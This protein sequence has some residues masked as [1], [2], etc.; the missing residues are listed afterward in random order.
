MEHIP[1][2]AEVTLTPEDVR[3]RVGGQFPDLG[4][5]TAEFLNE[6]FDSFAFL[7]D[8]RWV[9]LFPKRREREPL[10]LVSMRLLDEL[11][12][13]LP[14][15]VPQPTHWGRPDERFP[16][17]FVGY[18]LLPGTP[19]LEAEMPPRLQEAN[20]QRMGEFLAAL[21]AFP[22]DRA[23]ALG[24]PAEP[25]SGD[26]AEDLLDEVQSLAEKI[27]PRLP[28]ALRQACEPFLEG[29]VERPPPHTGPR[30]LTHSDL[31]AEHV[32][33]D[34][35]GRVCG[36]IDFGDVAIAEPTVDYVGLCVWQGWGFAQA[37]LAAA[38][39]RLNESS[40]RRLR[41]MARCLGLIG[42]GWADWQSP[43]RIGVYQQFLRNA[44]D[45]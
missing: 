39:R 14:L 10:L 28:A 29:T 2:K 30:C 3:A 27:E 20:A 44:F 36:L 34:G 16:F 24:V 42:I 23:E 35:A 37:A 40:E 9:F 6:G 4:V 25:T 11:Q 31:Q 45:A 12:G 18:A 22:A 1:W 41:F 7:V 21:H 38:G 17:H 5:Q 26:H 33:L 32:L 43:A 8:G 13:R 15:P 19:G